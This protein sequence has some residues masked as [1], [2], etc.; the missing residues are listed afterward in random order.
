MRSGVQVRATRHPD[1][2]KE[3]AELGLTD[4]MRMPGMAVSPEEL[5]ET[6]SLGLEIIL[7]EDEEGL[8]DAARVAATVDAAPLESRLP[9]YAPGLLQLAGF[10]VYVG[11]VDGK[12]VTTA[13]GYQTG[14][15]VGVFSVATHSPGASTPRLRRRDQSPRC[16][17]GVRV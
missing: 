8:A 16:P 6:S 2:E 12:P 17:E 7:V 1:V 10:S 3:A 4:R 15:D 11:R 13:L 14:T 9:M 5:A